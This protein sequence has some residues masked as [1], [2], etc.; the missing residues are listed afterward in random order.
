[1]TQETPVRE[2][3]G[4]GKKYEKYL[5]S[6]G[7]NTV[8]ELLYYFPRAYQNRG[9]VQPVAYAP[10]DNMPH[11][12]I[13]TVASEPRTALIRRG[14]S[15]LKFRAFD[16][17]GTV[18]IT[19][20]NQDYLK[21]IFHTG[22][23]FR[24]W[25]K[26][27]LEKR[28]LCMT[29]P[30][31]EPYIDG[32]PLP[33][34]VPVYPLFA[35]VNQKYILKLQS[36]IRPYIRTIVSDFIPDFVRVEN[37]LCTLVYALE[38]IHLPESEEALKAAI[39]RLTF[40]EL[41]IFALSLSKI[42]TVSEQKSAPCMHNSDISEFISHLSYSLTNAQ[43]KAISDI[44][45]DMC[46][47]SPIFEKGI[48]TDTDVGNSSIKPMNRIVVGDVGSGKT[49]CAAAAAYTACKNGFQCA[50]MVPTEIL[51]AQHYESLSPML[52]KL[53]VRCGFLTGSLS[54]KEKNATL[55]ALKSGKIDF[56]IGT[57]ALIQDRVAFNN[58]GL[59]ITDE[60]HR[61]GVM[62]RA[63]LAEKSKCAH[64]LVMSATPIPRTLSLMVYGDLD[65]SLI[66]EMPP[67]R[68]KVK[69][70]VV[71]ETY[72][73]R[74]NGFIRKQAQNGHQTYIVCPSIEEKHDD[75]DNA[76]DYNPFYS[77]ELA[78]GNKATFKAAVNFAEELKNTFPNL[79]VEFIHG[80][81]K[82]KEKDA[83]MSDFVEGSIDI[84]VSTTVIEVGINVPNATLMIVENAERYGLSQLHQLRGRV[85]RG[86]AESYCILVSDSSSE[87]SKE[88]LDIMHRIYDGYTI[89]EYDLKMRGPGEFFSSGGPIRQSG[90][91]GLDIA[92]SCTDTELLHRAF[93]SAK[94]VIT[95]LSSY[96]LLEEK[97]NEVCSKKANTIN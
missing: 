56:V 2:L 91:A 61:F 19:Y 64:V 54:A 88:R 68:K 16:E 7:L 90:D 9:D 89:A 73:S 71:D 57:H 83:V 65:I 70:F 67:G 30:S 45:Y 21:D 63:K 76:A 15:I 18:T 3:Y 48:I 20:F 41:F 66:D 50:L 69:T 87:N 74:L 47:K 39:R 27:S 31:Y 32:K 34:L 38:N 86:S 97:V 72:R 55:L 81:M 33:A 40:D 23:Q 25:G 24:F 51:A 82:S 43:R 28:T 62:Q 17:S 22:A 96:P 26:I 12:F 78:A 94:E 85:G 49:V 79:R 93:E 10:Q 5:S 44:I 6:N 4:V 59:V 75:I 11:S 77:F 37:S 46:Q 8:K 60:Q 52:E 84:L 14:M 36:G 29:S 35:G 42:K 80:K 53:G 95:S 1:M 92:K 58:L 13:L